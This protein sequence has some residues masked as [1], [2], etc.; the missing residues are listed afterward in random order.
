M[1][2]ISKVKRP[3]IA[4]AGVLMLTSSVPAFSFAQAASTGA[5][6]TAAKV[7]HEKVCN[8][9]KQLLETRFNNITSNSQKVDNKITTVD[10]KAVA[11]QTKK[12]LTVA[13]SLTD[14]VSTTKA[15]ADTAVA[16]LQ[17]AKPT[18]DCAS[19]TAASQVAA[20]KVQVGQTRDALKAY[21][22][23]VISYI[24]ALEQAKAS[25]GGNQ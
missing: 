5:A 21:R 9:H 8:A 4:L 16:N 1:P 2:K 7:N 3:A 23:A 15:A 11:Y 17:A 18:L 19:G 14:T 22:Q 12:N 25:T 10:S 24:Q 20:F 13:S 6:S